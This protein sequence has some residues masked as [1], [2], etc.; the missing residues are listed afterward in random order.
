MGISVKIVEVTSDFWQFRWE[1][2][3][4]NSFGCGLLSIEEIRKIG[5]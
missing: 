3:W 1:I 2:E 4:E 5:S